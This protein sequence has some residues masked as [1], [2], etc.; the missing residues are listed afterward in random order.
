M[1][2]GFLG[3]AVPT[4]VANEKTLFVAS[5][6]PDKLLRAISIPARAEEGSP[7]VSWE[8]RKGT[9][10]A[11]SPLLY[12]G[13]L[14]LVSDKGVLTCLDP[15]TGNVV[16]EG[17][18]IPIPTGVKASPVA[19]DGKI[20]LSGQDGDFFVIQAGPVHRVLSVNSLGGNGNV[21]ASPALSNGHLFLRTETHL[22]CIGNTSERESSPK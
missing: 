7:S 18:R 16:Y 3:N 12:E 20:L 5:G 1:V 22:F 9:G 15:E 2:E 14:Y 10:Y 21:Y 13:H 6:Y 17:G 19:W 8:Y 4:P 11:P